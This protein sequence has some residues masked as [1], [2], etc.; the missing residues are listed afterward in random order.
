MLKRNR[1]KDTAVA[2]F[3]AAAIAGITVGLIGFG[4]MLGE[5]KCRVEQMKEV[6][7]G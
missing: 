4:E 5:L 1:L 6:E 7:R 2:L 3:F